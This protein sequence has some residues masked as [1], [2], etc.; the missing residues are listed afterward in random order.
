MAFDDDI[1]AKAKEKAIDKLADVTGI[2]PNLLSGKISEA[3]DKTQTSEYA[4]H[5]LNSGRLLG[6]GDTLSAATLAYFG[7]NHRGMGN[8]I[9]RNIERYGLTFFTR[10]ELNLSYDNIIQDRTFTN[11]MDEDQLSLMRAIRSLLDPEGSDGA[12][13]QSQVGKQGTTVFGDYNYPSPIIDTRNPF[14]A[15]LS[16]NL[17]SVS[18]WPDPY[19]D[20]F[21]SDEGI[22][23]EQWGMVDGVAKIYNAFSLNC[24]FKNIV[25]DPITKIFHY[26]TQYSSFVYQGL[27]SPRMRNLLN[28]R[29]DYQTRIYRLVT[30][31]TKTKVLEIAAT[32]AAM[33]I[34][35]NLGR[36]FDFQND[37]PYNDDL[38][39]IQ[40]QF[41]CF[42]AI[43]NDPILI[44]S[45]NKT[46]QRFNPGM[47]DSVR[48]GLMVKLQGL[49]K[50]I[51][52]YYGYPRINPETMELEWWV[53]KPVY[54]DVM[55][56]ITRTNPSVKPVTD[57]ASSGIDRILNFLENP[58]G[59]LKNEISQGL[60]KAF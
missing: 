55:A 56:S 43:Y 38:D 57:L 22:Q 51:F 12:P 30:D 59:A 4:E 19:V 5:I 3:F 53:D 17:I 39:Q 41:Q 6:L 58:T 15:I 9:P 8:P 31:I 25:D 18:G 48:E 46:Q 20:T 21:T 26:W 37:R 1:K 23:K 2:D 10:P 35:N 42:G 34:T 28:N 52:N 32:G 29:I 24:T 40:V 16:N 45:F 13:S 49:E 60:K 47:S 14:M 11:L 44:W 50:T 36:K 33:P 27:M 54:L 7:H